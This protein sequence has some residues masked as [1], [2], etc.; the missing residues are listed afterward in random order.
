MLYN[1]AWHTE[2]TTIHAQIHHHCMRELCLHGRGP[3]EIIDAIKGIF[4]VHSS[5]SSCFGVISHEALLASAFSTAASGTSDG[6]LLCCSKVSAAAAW[7]SAAMAL[8][9]ANMSGKY[10]YD[11]TMTLPLWNNV[12]TYNIEL[13]VHCAAF[14]FD[15]DMKMHWQLGASQKT[16]MLCPAGVSRSRVTTCLIGS[17]QPQKLLPEIAY[18]L[19]VNAKSEEVKALTSCQHHNLQALWLAMAYCGSAQ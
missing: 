7:S 17:R 14:L 18:S 6:K 9:T 12:M 15:V 19:G 8:A 5:S 4:I 11:W 16:W 1:L 2:S 3:S 10:G 13:L